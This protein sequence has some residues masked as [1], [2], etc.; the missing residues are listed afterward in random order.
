MT[1]E[2]AQF[3]AKARNDLSDAYISDYGTGDEAAISSTTAEAAIQTATRFVD[4]IASVL[5]SA[6]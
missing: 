3:L 5:T 4:Y 2:A 6:G 1:P